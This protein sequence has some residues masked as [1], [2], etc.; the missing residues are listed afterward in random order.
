MYANQEIQ[1]TGRLSR[2]DT[3][4]QGPELLDVRESKCRVGNPARRKTHEPLDKRQCGPWACV[5]IQESRRWCGSS[6]VEFPLGDGVGVPSPSLKSCPIR[7]HRL[8]GS[9][10]LR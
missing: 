1:R 2:D 7:F 3:I 6:G 9:S 10:A 5:V 4:P 8:S